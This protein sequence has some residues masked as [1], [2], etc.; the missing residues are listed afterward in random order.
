MN[1]KKVKESAW[2]KFTSIVAFTLPFGNGGAGTPVK[3]FPLVFMA[4]FVTA[5]VIYDTFFV[6]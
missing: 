1:D 5:L 4:V 6:V 3:L 2:S